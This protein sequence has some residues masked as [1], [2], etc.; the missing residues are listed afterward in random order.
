[1]KRPWVRILAAVV[2]TPL[3]FWVLPYYLVRWSG[4]RVVVFVDGGDKTQSQPVDFSA[5]PQE[6]SLSQPAPGA[7]ARNAVLLLADGLG[8]SQLY[9]ARIATRGV[10]GRLTLERFPITGWQTNPSL[11][12]VYTDSAA[13]ASS[14]LS[15]RKVDTRTL[16]IDGDGHP[17]ATLPEALRDRGFSIGLITDS[18]IWD[19]S[20]VAAAVHHDYRYDLPAVAAQLA[21]SR[22]DLI[23]GTHA[24]EGSIRVELPDGEA[25]LLAQLR[26]GGYVVHDPPAHLPGLDQPTVLLYAEDQIAEEGR[27]PDLVSWAIRKLAAKSRPYY[28]FVET[29][30][31]DSGSHNSDFGMVVRGVR[32]L[33]EV[34]QV[35]VEQTTDTLV[36]ATADHETG[37]FAILSGS[38]EQPLAIRWA[39]PRHTAEPVPVLAYGPGAERFSGVMDNT[40]IAGRIAASLGIEWPPE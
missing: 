11:D 33:D 10:H 20:L 13:S 1:M 39:T 18:Y 29:E 37:G 19:A 16:S 12:D 38:A 2:A 27:L 25:G 4:Y 34:A 7:T 35:I 24:G 17:V 6:V 21:N 22:F 26:Q 40:E 9:A 31:P 32:E 8:F 5:K 30:D 14:I 36:V 3:L 28:L 15:G 23:V